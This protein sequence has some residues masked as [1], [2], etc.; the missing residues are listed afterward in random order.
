MDNNVANR[1]IGMF[2]VDEFCK[3]VK[4]YYWPE[5]VKKDLSKNHILADK[6][7]NIPAYAN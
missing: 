5:Y 6:S 4:P 7:V 1:L 3:R 2:G